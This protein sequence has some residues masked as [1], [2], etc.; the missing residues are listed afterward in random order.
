[1]GIQMDLLG[2]MADPL[3]F[4][5]ISVDQIDHLAPESDPNS[6]DAFRARW[7]GA[8][9][10]GIIEAL[11][12]GNGSVSRAP[13]YCLSLWND[14]GGW[15]IKE[16]YALGSGGGGGP[17][18]R[19]RYASREAA[20]IVAFRWKMRSLAAVM[21][22]QRDDNATH[23]T[24]CDQLARWMISQCPPLRF[25]GVNLAEEFE[26]MKAAAREKSRL[27]WIALNAAFDL[28]RKAEEVARG[29]GAYAFSGSTMAGLLINPDSVKPHEE[30]GGFPA[31]WNI[32]G[33]AP[34]RLE[35][36]IYPRS[37]QASSPT[38]LAALEAFR[39]QLKV[40]VSIAAEDA[41][42]PHARPSYHDGQKDR[43]L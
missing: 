19:Q 11:T 32:G 5:P 3:D 1:M 13:S 16:D 40:P 21:S 27:R 26:V 8:E 37:G 25:G 14:D 38:V 36:T 31:T 10:A 34:D 2:L 17:F 39:A 24:H 22:D 18:G 33:H 9:G 28:D 7:V 23:R 30:A 6:W 12:F 42:Y 43:W 15:R 29:I 35:I 41:P 4:R 20:I